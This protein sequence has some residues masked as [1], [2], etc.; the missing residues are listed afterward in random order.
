MFSRWSPWT[1]IIFP[2][3]GCWTIL[4]LVQNLCVWKHFV[5]I[6][7]W[8]NGIG[9]TQ[10]F[11]KAFITRGRSNCSGM[12]WQVV[13]VFLPL[14]CWILMSTLDWVE[15]G[16]SSFQS[17]LKGSLARRFSRSKDINNKRWNNLHTN[18]G[19][20]GGRWKFQRGIMGLCEESVIMRSELHNNV[21]LQLIIALVFGNYSWGSPIFRDNQWYITPRSRLSNPW[22]AACQWKSF[23]LLAT[24]PSDSPAHR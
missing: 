22:R 3:V 17:S 24:T 13:K 15:L 23:I 9:R 11:L 18:P 10:T 5:S 6:G 4:P 14:R 19:F 2:I 21:D 12:P 20:S 16:S 8:M 1:W 7:Y